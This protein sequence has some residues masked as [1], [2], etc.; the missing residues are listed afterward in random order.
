MASVFHRGAGRSSQ[1]QDAERALASYRRQRPAASAA[2]GATRS[3]DRACVYLEHRH[4]ACHRRP[5]GEELAR[6][7]HPCLAPGCLA[8]AR[9]RVTRVGDRRGIGWPQNA[10]RLAAACPPENSQALAAAP[11]IRPGGDGQQELPAGASSMKRQ[12]YPC[13]ATPRFVR[14]TA[15]YCSASPTAMLSQFARTRSSTPSPASF[16]PPAL[17]PPPP[18]RVRR[19]LATRNRTPEGCP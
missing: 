3:R 16:H 19:S 12:H 11:G 7:R 14:A 1:H 6:G 9:Q 5:V 8:E 10:W 13:K 15:L 2:S 17:P 18:R 4:L